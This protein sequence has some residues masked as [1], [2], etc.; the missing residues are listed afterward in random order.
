MDPMEECKKWT[1]ASVVKDAGKISLASDTNVP[2]VRLQTERDI[3][4]YAVLLFET[5]RVDVYSVHSVRTARHEAINFMIPCT[6][7]SRYLGL[8]I[9]GFKRR[10]RFYLLFT[11]LRLERA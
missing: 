6:A 2:V 11:F 1:T 3:A 10:M 4:W 9:E 5:P 8:S 7:S